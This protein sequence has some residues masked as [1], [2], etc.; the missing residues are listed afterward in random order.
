[1]TN[2]QIEQIDEL[3]EDVE[4]I[5]QQGHI[6]DEKLQNIICNYKKFALILKDQDKVIGALQTYT[7]YSEI[8]VDDIWINPKYRRQN[9]GRKLLEKLEEKF[10]GKGYNNINLVTSHF[11]NTPEFYKKCGFELEFVRTN[12]ANPTL[13]KSFFIKYFKDQNQ[14]QGVS[15]KNENS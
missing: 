2:Y 14:Y 5:I 13:S 8:Y 9:L 6:Q 12:K 10:T 7:A 15:Q 4:D 1:M 11:A 3:P